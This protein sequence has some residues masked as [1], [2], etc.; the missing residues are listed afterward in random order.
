MQIDI[1]TLLAEIVNFL[2]LIWLLQRFLYKPV[3]NIM[4]EREEKI[5]HRLQEAERKRQEAQ[6]E[7]Q[8]YRQLQEELD[9]QR[10]ERLREAREEANTRRESLI[11]QAREEVDEMRHSWQL[12]VQQEKDS[13]LHDFEA[14]IGQSAVEVARR[15]LDEMA[16]ARLESQVVGVFARR[17]RNAAE[18][19]RERLANA[20]RD[21]SVQ[22]ESAFEL[23]ST[24]RD[25]IEQ[26]LRSLHDDDLTPDYRVR[27]EMLCG[28]RLT[29][30]EYRVSWSFEDYTASLRREFAE[31]IDEA[32]G[33]QRQATI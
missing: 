21:K 28:I 11:K 25:A 2:I 9:S 30:G 4:R 12:A 8:K 16:D 22:V 29:T 13:F 26:A 31:V 14:R 33:K 1:F 24:D 32:T 15:A 17:L 27:P 20:L 19:D 5:T 6:D 10:D 3:V 23:S 7:A 18:E